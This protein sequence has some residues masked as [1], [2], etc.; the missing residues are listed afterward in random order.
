MEEWIQE[1]FRF[2]RTIYLHNNKYELKCA[3]NPGPYKKSLFYFLQDEYDPANDQL[4]ASKMEIKN[5]MIGY[6]FCNYYPSEK[7]PIDLPIVFQFLDEFKNLMFEPRCNKIKELKNI[8]E[9]ILEEI[10]KQF[11]SDLFAE[12]IQKLYEII[13]FSLD[14]YYEKYYIYCFLCWIEKNFFRL[15]EKIDFNNPKVKHALI[16]INSSILEVKS[17]E[18]SYEHNC[19][20][21]CELWK[22]WN[23]YIDPFF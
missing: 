20:Q 4:S 9:D 1:Q 15:L 14:S 8:S 5:M 23:K 19:M 16:K 10:W 7:A 12:R 22:K 13:Q 21:F 17:R 6:Q 11:Y 3:I 2:N 18:F